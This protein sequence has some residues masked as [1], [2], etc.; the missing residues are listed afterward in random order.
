MHAILVFLVIFIVLPAICQ[1]ASEG[2]GTFLFYFS[3]FFLILY[4]I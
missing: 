4:L 1:A 2:A 3:T